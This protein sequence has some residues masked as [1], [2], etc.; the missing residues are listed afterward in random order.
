MDSAGLNAKPTAGL[1]PGGLDSYVP[2]LNSQANY[3]PVAAGF[4]PADRQG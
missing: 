3:S 4:F 1:T 2:G